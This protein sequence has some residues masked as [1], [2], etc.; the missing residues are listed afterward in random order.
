MINDL[1]PL[2]AESGVESIRKGA[3]VLKLCR[4][5]NGWTISFQEEQMALNDWRG[6]QIINYLIR[7]PNQ[8][9]QCV[10]LYNLGTTSA[11][12]SSSTDCLW[13]SRQ[14]IVDQTAVDD[15]NR[16]VTEITTKLVLAHEEEDQ[17]TVDALEEEKEILR[18]EIKKLE[19]FGKLKCFANSG[20]K[21]RKAVRK[22]IYAVLAKI[23][24][25]CPKTHQQLAHDITT[26]GSCVI[27]P[28]MGVRYTAEK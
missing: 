14:E 17:E 15:Y 22:A 18:K 1:S 19:F 4:S 16:R 25:R 2:V 9:I 5:G 6:V 23:K 8:W 13:T 26:G 20:E 21:A 7:Q 27:S 24:H 28:S 3:N 11:D 10:E 12:E